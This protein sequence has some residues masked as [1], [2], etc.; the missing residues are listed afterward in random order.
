MKARLIVRDIY[1]YDY[2]QILRIYDGSTNFVRQLILDTTGI[3]IPFQ[4]SVSLSKI[5]PTKDTNLIV[6]LYGPTNYEENPYGRNEYNIICKFNLNGK[7]LW[8][9]RLDHTGYDRLTIYY[10]NITNDNGFFLQG[11]LFKGSE[12]FLFFAKIDSVGKI[13][14]SKIQNYSDKKINSYYKIQAL[15]NNNYY[16]IYGDVPITINDTLKTVQFWMMIVDS[17]ANIK[18]EYIWKNDS[19]DYSVN[20]ISAKSNGNLLILGRDGGNKF[21]L[22]EISPDYITS[23]EKI[24]YNFSSKLNFNVSPNPASDFIVIQPSEGWQAS[25]GSDIQIYNT[26]GE[27]VL[28]VEQTSPSVQKDRHF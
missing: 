25:E 19:T 17:N 12:R 3:G 7:L 26:L 11:Q 18:E 15:L 22:A 4:N 14:W 8:K 1:D 2:K 20:S 28:Q 21:Y 9:F 10:S 13:E 27:I 24:T 16:A 6:S 5:F 23:V